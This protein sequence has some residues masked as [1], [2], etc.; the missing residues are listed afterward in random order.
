MQIK[1]IYYA[2]FFNLLVPCLIFA[3]GNLSSEKAKEILKQVTTPQS[4][5][6]EDVQKGMKTKVYKRLNP[7]GT[8]DVRLETE[9]LQQNAGTPIK[10]IQIFNREGRWLIRQ[11]KAARMDMLTESGE[12]AKPAIED[13]CDYSLSEGTLNGIECHVVEVTIPKETQEAIANAFKSNSSLSKI[14]VA[15][16][17]PAKRKFYIGKTNFFTYS[18]Q[19]FGRSGNLINQESYSNVQFNIALSDD[20]FAIPT[21]M[22]KVVVKSLRDFQTL[23][24]GPNIA[25]GEKLAKI[26]KP[27][28]V[29]T[30][31]FSFFALSSLFCLIYF[32]LRKKT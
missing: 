31:V 24:P 5:Y 7:D 27:S 13:N 26:R 2:V 28:W 8:E 6:A 25:T 29:K 3:D 17:V 14:N 23:P 20:L 12:G 15:D 11:N 18:V 10:V 1:S 30:T 21:N 9:P 4:F 19:T 16:L 32:G 22:T